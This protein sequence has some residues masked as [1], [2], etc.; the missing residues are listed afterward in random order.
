[1]RRFKCRPGAQMLGRWSLA[2]QGWTRTGGR[3]PF[4]AN[5]WETGQAVVAPHLP[6]GFLCTHDYR[7]RVVIAD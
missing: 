7:C 5:M 1:M 6:F 3:R 4:Q 2:R